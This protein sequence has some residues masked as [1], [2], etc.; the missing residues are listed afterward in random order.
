VGADE[1]TDTGDQNAHYPV[2][3]PIPV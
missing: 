3:T 1:A 2:T